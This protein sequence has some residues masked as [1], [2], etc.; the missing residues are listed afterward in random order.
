[1]GDKEAYIVLTDGHSLL[2][3]MLGRL[4]MTIDDCIYAY[5]S[6]SDR[7]FQRTGLGLTIRGYVQGRFD[8]MELENAIK[9]IIR[10]QGLEMD[11]TLEG[12]PETSC[13]V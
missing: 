13:K 10:E 1:M 11:A 5:V 12:S 8:S 9:Q 4:R 2:A 7:V 3:I 6:L